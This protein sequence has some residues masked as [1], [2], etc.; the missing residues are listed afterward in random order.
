MLIKIME[1]DD[2]IKAPK[3][4]NSLNKYLAK[5]D[6]ILENKAISRLL[7]ISEQEVERL[8]QEAIVE[9]RKAMVDDDGDSS[10]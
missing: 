7:L 6:R 1:E 3:Y 4:G 10:L 8:Y 5:N 9:L 2:F